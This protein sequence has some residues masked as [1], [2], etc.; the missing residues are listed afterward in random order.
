MSFNILKV[1]YFVDDSG[2]PFHRLDLSYNF[3]LSFPAIN[4]GRFFCMC[5]RL[6]DELN[7]LP[8]PGP[9]PFTM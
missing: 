4:V 3:S 1:A 9:E 5:E 2:F 7:S 8:L 6:T